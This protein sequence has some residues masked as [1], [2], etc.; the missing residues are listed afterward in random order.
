MAENTTPPRLI[1]FDFDGVIA[2]SEVLACEA[3]AA[4]AG[5]LGAPMIWQEA[6]KLFV[7]KRASDE[8]ATMEALAGRPLPDFLPE[9]ER[10][11]FALFERSLRPIPGVA[12]FIARHADMPRCIASSSSPRR[13]ALCLGVMGLADRFP[14]GIYSAETVARG[15]PFPD[16]FLKAAH[17]EGVEPRDAIVIED[18]ASGVRAA[19]AAGMR[20]IGLVA[21]SHLPPDHESA[22]VAAGATFIARDYDEVARILTGL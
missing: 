1:I 20:V 14:R 10:R 17:E 2:D 6:A 22:L 8:V 9:L 19:V 7:G 15:K 12:D 21:A 3:L 4:Y 5:D 16:I 18:S 11:T 13:I